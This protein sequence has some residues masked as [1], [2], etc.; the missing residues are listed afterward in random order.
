MRKLRKCVAAFSAA[1]LTAA[2]L[3][4]GSASP[5]S[6]YAG[7][8][9]IVGTP[10]ALYLDYEPRMFHYQLSAN[11]NKNNVDIRMYNASG[12]LMWSWFSPDDRVG[13]RW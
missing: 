2:L 11:R 6:A 1:T 4:F 5:A 12:Q 9:G 7:A 10:F 13:G 3:V 8:C